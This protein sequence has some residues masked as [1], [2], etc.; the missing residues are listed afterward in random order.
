MISNG[1]Y[2][3]VSFYRYWLRLIYNNKKKFIIKKGVKGPVSFKTRSN[4]EYYSFTEV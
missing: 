3:N 1:V 2:E 4:A